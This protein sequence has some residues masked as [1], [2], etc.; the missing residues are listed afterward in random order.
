MD[1]PSQWEW[2]AS[3]I[4]H[5][6]VRADAA[7][8]PAMRLA[9]LSSRA[10]RKTAGSETSSNDVSLPSQWTLSGETTVRSTRNA[11]SVDTVPTN[12]NTITAKFDPDEFPWI[13]RDDIAP[14][15][16]TLRDGGYIGPYDEEAVSMTS[17]TDTGTAQD[18]D[19]QPA[20]VTYRREINRARRGSSDSERDNQ[21]IKPAREVLFDILQATPTLDD[22]SGTV[23]P[24]GASAVDELLKK[25]TFL[26]L[27]ALQSLPTERDGR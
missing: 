26:D 15:G 18:S 13:S 25:W 24:R 23:A 5:H 11:A 4:Y 2:K 3:D 27:D 7:A 6:N 1:I 19:S 20:V 8:A 14:L 12:Q 21:S 10:D 22:V 9:P 17:S 16:K